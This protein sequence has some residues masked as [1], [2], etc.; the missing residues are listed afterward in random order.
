MASADP[1]GR[2]AQA[3]DLETA[4]RRLVTAVEQR[5]TVAWA[6]SPALALAQVEAG[7]FRLVENAVPMER[8]VWDRRLGTVVQP[9][10]IVAELLVTAVKDGKLPNIPGS[11]SL[12]MFCAR[13]TMKI[14]RRASRVPVLPAT[15]PLLM[16][17][18][19]QVRAG[20]HATVATSTINAAALVA[21]AG[22]RVRTAAL[23]VRGDTVD[24]AEEVISLVS[25]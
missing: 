8:R 15:F 7:A 17:A 3:Q 2:L 10:G 24:A 22:Q 11:C 23:G 5:T 1:T 20:G 4:V 12:D 18:V 25:L 13:L 9:L 19:A 21:S 16:A 6:A 14:A